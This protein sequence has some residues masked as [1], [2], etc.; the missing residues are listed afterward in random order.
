MNIRNQANR[1]IRMAAAD[2][3]LYL[4]EVAESLGIADGTLSRKLRNEMSQDEK[5][6]VLQAIEKMKK[7]RSK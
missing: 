7:N 4:W 2:A 6:T 1:D 5:E 3:G